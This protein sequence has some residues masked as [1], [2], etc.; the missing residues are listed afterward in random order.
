MSNLKELFLLD[1]TVV[2]LNHGSFGACPRPVFENYQWWQRELER[3]PVEFLGRR[4]TELLGN[5]RA[6]LAAY[7]GAKADEIVYFPNPTHAVNMIARS[8]KLRPG[9]EILAT[10]HEY[11]ALD[12]T[13]AL[14]GKK[15]GARYARHSIPLPV[16][17]HANFVEHFWAAVT[18][19]TRLIFLS[20]ITSPTALIFPAK[21]IC[22][23]ARE[24][25]I[26]T[27]VDGAHAP[28]HIP[29]DLHDL[30]CD[31]YTGAGHKWLCGPKGSAFL[32]ARREVQE[33]LE[34]L[35]V[36]WG[37]GD[38]NIEPAPEMGETQFIRFHQWQGTRDIAAYLATPAAIEFQRQHNWEVVRRECNARA[39]ETR[40][41]LNA[42]T[43]LEPLCPDS[44]EWF[45]QMF[46]A[47]LPD[48]ANPDA[49]KARLYAEHRIEAPIFQ[50]NGMNLIRVSFQ[51]YNTRA[52]ADKLMDAL[53]ICLKN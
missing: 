36:S 3:Q 20:H 9:D 38:E 21:E 15:T 19:R 10:D 27:I 40:T 30:D 48:S 51:G 7:L 12:R 53:G 26:L 16:T 2:Y 1:P 43:G 5:A 50:W 49:L 24:R 35:V 13:W 34:P 47:R 22:R 39:R 41:R 42:L 11:G 33:W 29:L 28:G 23:R 46:A 8:L 6:A 17:S 44:G 32:Y 31:L 52:D 45:A 25:G 14:I 4:S 37:W 18:E